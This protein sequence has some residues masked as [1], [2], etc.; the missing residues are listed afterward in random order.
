RRCHRRRR[1]YTHCEHLP[2]ITLSQR[3]L[4]SHAM[5]YR[6]ACL[7][8][9]CLLIAPRIS[10]ADDLPKPLSAWQLR[11]AVAQKPTGAALDRL[12]QHIEATFGKKELE[13]G[14]A[15]PRVED[16]LACWAVA[17]TPKDANESPPRVVQ[18]D[19]P[20]HWDL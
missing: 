17:H 18:T 1:R 10:A 3:L 12:R 19:G 7:F 14:A 6:I 2:S 4:R 11:S 9:V 15:R 13:N 5:P 16:T 8:A 20:R